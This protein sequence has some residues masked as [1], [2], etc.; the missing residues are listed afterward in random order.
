MS[1][2]EKEFCDSN[3]GP[4]KSKPRKTMTHKLTLDEMTEALK[5][6]GYL[7]ESEISSLLSKTG[8]FVES[9]Q[10]ILDPLTGKSRELDLLAEFYEHRPAS[11]DLRCCSIVKYAFEIKNNIYPLVLLT[12]F[13]SSPNIENWLGLKEA[14]NLPEGIKYDSSES[15]YD[16]LINERSEHIFSQFC[17]FQKKKANED[18]MAVHPENLHPGLMKLVQYCEEQVEMMDTDLIYESPRNE[19]MDYFRHFLY[20]P[21]LLINDDLYEF[22]DGKMEKRESSVL[23]FNYHYKGDPKMA[24]VFVLT[25]PG[26]KSFIYQM[27]E[28]ERKVETLMKDARSKCI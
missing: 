27:I 10:V 7:L 15:Y 4:Q 13:K 22:K 17:S 3:T 6:S 23:V 12:Q 24:Y 16:N 21:V 2:A 8:F 11:G 14:L 5:R 19:K 25:K 9:N 28:L 20:L 26:F 18:L 1:E